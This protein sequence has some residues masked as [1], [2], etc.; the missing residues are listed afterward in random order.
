MTKHFNLIEA[1]GLQDVWDEIPEPNPDPI[2]F[3]FPDVDRSD[4]VW[5]TKQDEYYCWQGTRI[6]QWFE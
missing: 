2:P 3:I 5:E 1:E 6:P 4:E